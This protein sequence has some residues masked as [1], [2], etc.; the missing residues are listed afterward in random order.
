LPNL[1][2]SSITAKSSSNGQNIIQSADPTHFRLIQTTLIV[3]KSDFHTF[4][5]PEERTLKVVLKGIP[6]NIHT[7]K[8]ITESLNFS[9][10]FVRRFSTPEKPMLICI[11][12]IAA[13]PNAK[14]IFLLNNL[15]YLRISVEVLK[16]SGPA[17]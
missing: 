1:I 12:H 2:P 9:V 14:D 5:H 11:V 15:L 17:Q 7:D 8:L 4:S 6:I 16:A 10:K 3:N 13:T